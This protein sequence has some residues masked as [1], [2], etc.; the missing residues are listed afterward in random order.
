MRGT[1]PF[2]IEYS[3]L[4]ES[5]DTFRFSQGSIQE[6]PYVTKAVDPGVYTVRIYSF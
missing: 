3:V 2:T 6:S 4:T 1:P 5:G